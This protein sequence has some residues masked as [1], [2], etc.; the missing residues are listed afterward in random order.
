MK[1]CLCRLD[2]VNDGAARAAID[3]STEYYR[4]NMRLRLRSPAT[5]STPHQFYGTVTQFELC[6]MDGTRLRNTLDCTASCGRAS[7]DA[8]WRH[9]KRATLSAT[10]SGRSRACSQPHHAPSGAQGIC[11]TAGLRDAATHCSP[12]APAELQL[13]PAACGRCGLERR[14]DVGLARLELGELHATRAFGARASLGAGEAAVAGKGMAG[15][16]RKRDELDSSPAAP[17]RAVRCDPRRFEV[18]VLCGTA[19]AAATYASNSVCAGRTGSLE[20]LL[21]HERQVPVDVRQRHA[22]HVSGRLHAI[23]KFRTP[24]PCVQRAQSGQGACAACW[25]WRRSGG[26]RLAANAGVHCGLRRLMTHFLGRLLAQQAAQHAVACASFCAATCNP[27]EHRC[28]ACAPPPGRACAQTCWRRLGHHSPPTIARVPVALLLVLLLLVCDHKRT[29]LQRTQRL[30]MRLTASGKARPHGNKSW[31][32]LR[33]TLAEGPIAHHPLLVFF[34]A[35]CAKHGVVCTTQPWYARRSQR[36]PRRLLCPTTCACGWSSSA[37]DRRAHR[38]CATRGRQ[39]SSSKSQGRCNRGHGAARACHPQAAAPKSRARPAAARHGPRWWVYWALWAGNACVTASPTPLVR[40][41][42][43][44]VDA[45]GALDG[46]VAVVASTERQR[47]AY[48]DDR[49]HARVSMGGTRQ[50]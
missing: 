35:A 48:R 43:R 24:G 38:R 20:P 13:A 37:I 23:L 7:A 29:L 12:S 14:H 19:A 36:R 6:A 47:A 34:C 15:R 40:C 28:D 42:S 27:D 4:R 1:A 9:T 44:A 21:V 33:A 2:T 8:A 10:R 26:V 50:R 18:A 30:R 11:A 41:C 45:S 16:K 31:R 5:S 39:T 17:Q 22:A 3:P 25:R 49:E 46:P 32:R